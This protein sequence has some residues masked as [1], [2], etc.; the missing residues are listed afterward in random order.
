MNLTENQTTEFKREYIDDIKKTVIAFANTA[1]GRIYI[2]IADNGEAVGVSDADEVVLKASNAVRDSIRPD[3]TMFVSYQIDKIDDKDVVVL[4]I[5]KGTASPYYLESKGIRPSG[6]YVRQGASSVPAT[7][8]AI[9]KMIKDTD[10]AKY[11][12][13]RCTNQ[14]LTFEYA[15]KEFEHANVEFGD[16]Q[17][18]SLK[19]INEDGMFT[20]LAQLLSEQ[21]SH[22]IKAA[23]FDGKEKMNFKDRAE[24]TGSILKQI[25]DAYEYI[26]RYNRTRSEF[27]DIHRIDIRDYPM[28]AIREALLNAVVHRDYAFSGSILIS[29]FDDRIEFVSIGGL[30]KGISYE[31]M[32]L[33]VSIQRNENLANVFYRL[34]LIEAFGTGIPKIMRCYAEY[35]QT[36]EIIVTDNAFKIILPNKS[37]NNSSSEKA[38]SNEEKIMRLVSEKKFVNRKE[39][40]NLLDI[41]QA[42]AARILRKMV[43]ENKIKKVGSGKNVSYIK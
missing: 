42:S 17:K 33:G 9:L 4:N 25:N 27:K 14:N 35:S 28:E 13:I 8:T 43:D 20:N 37:D 19:L 12:E 22:S 15:Q 38:F 10:G 34:N 1:G 26:N 2:G 5:Q 39:V 29:I 18:K 24:F 31:D 11:E 6:V 30:V 7:E 23:V 32:L 40:E 3:V 36:P 21:C 41:S 16:N